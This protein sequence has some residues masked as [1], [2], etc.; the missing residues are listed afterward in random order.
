MTQGGEVDRVRKGDKEEGEWGGGG[1]R[2]K[3]HKLD[4]TIQPNQGGRKE[5]EGLGLYKKEETSGGWAT[6]LCC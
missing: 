6:V 1:K 2:K 3:G 4:E 5:E